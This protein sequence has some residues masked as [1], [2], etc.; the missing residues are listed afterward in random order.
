M[1]DLAG[2][3]LNC[4]A[5]DVSVSTIEVAVL[6]P[7]NFIGD[8]ATVVLTATL[9]LNAQARHDIGLFL[10]VDGGDAI[11]GSCDVSVLPYQPDP[12]YLDLDGTDDDPGGAIQDTCGDIDD[13]H[14]P[15]VIEVGEVTLT[16]VD[17][18][19]DGFLDLP[20]G[21][22][23]RQP[24]ANDLCTSPMDA[25]PGAPSKCRVET[26]NINVKVPPDIT[27]VSMS[28]IGQQSNSQQRL[29]ALA[30]QV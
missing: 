15:A 25:F 26:I 10:G 3:D 9:D 24:G 19:M 8:T 1:A 7:C 18:D 13:A 14:T 27:A 16:C 21:T 29:R 28:D 30:R 2:F 5:N 11:T 22:S 6:E 12:P 23:W 20:T 4:T 17:E